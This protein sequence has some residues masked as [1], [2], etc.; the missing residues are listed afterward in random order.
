MHTLSVYEIWREI[1]LEKLEDI[2]KM[3]I[4]ETAN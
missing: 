3:D 1:P 4:Q 2:I